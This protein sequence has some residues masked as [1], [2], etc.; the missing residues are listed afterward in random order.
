MGFCFF[1]LLKT[2]CIEHCEDAQV[3]DTFLEAR[4]SFYIERIGIAMHWRERI[5]YMLGRNGIAQM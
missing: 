1:V 4:Q 2:S 3:T 5:K